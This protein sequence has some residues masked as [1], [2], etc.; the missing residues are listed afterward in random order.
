MQQLKNDNSILLFLFLKLI[1]INAA[2]HR[3]D[4]LL[5]GSFLG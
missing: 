3:L 5:I 4:G 2:L 1:N